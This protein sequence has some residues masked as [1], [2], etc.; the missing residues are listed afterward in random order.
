[1]ILIIFFFFS[2]P[3]SASKNLLFFKVFITCLYARNAA[4]RIQ[5][6]DT[7]AAARINI[8][9]F[10]FPFPLLWGLELILTLFSCSAI[11]CLKFCRKSVFWLKYWVT[12]ACMLKFCSVSSAVGLLSNQLRTSME[13][14]KCTEFKSY[15]FWYGLVEQD[16][17]WFS[18]LNASTTV[19]WIAHPGILNP[20]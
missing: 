2:L 19:Q 6:D 3:S 16:K 11:F 13:H 5:E 8:F 10:R 15:Q 7:V 14:W 1:M 9:F 12:H 4:T 17:I 20:Y 18:A